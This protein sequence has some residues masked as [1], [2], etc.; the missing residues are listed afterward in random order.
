MITNQTTVRFLARSLRRWLR[1][2]CLV[3]TLFVVLILVF[4]HKN[5]LSRETSKRA[6]FEVFS[7]QANS[8]PY[9]DS[10]N[11]QAAAYCLKSGV[12]LESL[13]ERNSCVKRGSPSSSIYKEISIPDLNYPPIWVRIYSN[14]NSNKESHMNIWGRL[15]GWFLVLCILF[16][17][18]FRSLKLFPL[19]AL[20]PPVLLC[21][22]RGN[23]DGFVFAILFSALLLFR[24]KFL[25][26]AVI[27]LTAC[28]KFFPGL[29]LLA[30]LRHRRNWFA[31]SVGFLV[32]SI[33]LFESLMYLKG[34]F[35]AT[36]SGY[37]SGFG[38]NGFAKFPGIAQYSWMSLVARLFIV[39]LAVGTFI[40]SARRA[41]HFGSQRFYLSDHEVQIVLASLVLFVLIYLL[42]VSW[43]YRVIFAIPAAVLLSRVPLLSAKIFVILFFVLLWAPAVAGWR[44]FCLFATPPFFAAVFLI[45]QLLEVRGARDVT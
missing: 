40:L 23:T 5:F 6:A 38:L 29:A 28:L 10:R 33:P 22:E 11:I 15:N 31:L 25:V 18:T 32:F 19:L 7:V 26:G 41:R 45:P 16:L 14:F 2:E 8:Y 43:A 34:V 4:I 21:I 12:P 9:G 39:C 20:S 30:F 44:H 42:S 1:A 3:T 35:A 24:S 27:A 13:Y 37:E 17:C 36:P